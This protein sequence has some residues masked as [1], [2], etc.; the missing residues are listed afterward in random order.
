M[1]ADPDPALHSEATAAAVEAAPGTEHRRQ[2]TRHRRLSV[3]HMVGMVSMTGEQKIER[4]TAEKDI[5]GGTTQAGAND[6]HRRLSEV[7]LYTREDHPPLDN[8]AGA[9]PTAPE[10]L[11]VVSAVGYTSKAG[12]ESGG[13]KKTNQDAFVVL[14]V[15]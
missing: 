12:F 14:P 15:S 4:G 2:L 5:T 6:R 3:V 7:G 8:G 9:D 1:P 11:N 13:H 10:H